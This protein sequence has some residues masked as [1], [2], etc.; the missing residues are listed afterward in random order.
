MASGDGVGRGEVDE[1]EEVEG[2]LWV[3]WR[4]GGPPR[5]RSEVLILLGRPCWKRQLVP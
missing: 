4:D 1:E 3:G 5:L 2:K